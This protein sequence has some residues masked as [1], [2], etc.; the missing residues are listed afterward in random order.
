MFKYY[1]DILFVYSLPDHLEIKDKIL[2]NLT[3]GGPVHD[4]V[5]KVGISKTDYHIPYK[6]KSHYFKI[7]ENS[8]QKHLH[9]LIAKKFE[10]V[11]FSIQKAWYQQYT[12]NN[13]HNWHYHGECNMIGVYFLE[14]PDTK[15]KTQ[16][17]DMIRDKHIEY[18]AK[19]GDIVF[20]N[21]LTMHQSPILESDKRKTVISLN[22][23]ITEVD[24]HPVEVING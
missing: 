14:L 23:N 6:E 19:E 17:R 16:F 21:S 18:E 12:N 10:C 22:Y 13:G 20:T 7:L 8:L 3:Q 4:S 15:F 11:E 1:G 24:T 2:S 9:P 5:T